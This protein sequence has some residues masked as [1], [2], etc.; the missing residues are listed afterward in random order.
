MS[1]IS[2]PGKNQC[3]PF[4]KR[5]PSHKTEKTLSLIRL[6]KN[7]FGKYLP[8]TLLTILVTLSGAGHAWA[9]GGDTCRQKEQAILEQLEIAQED[10]NPGRIQGLEKALKNIRAWCSDSGLLAK[11]NK[12]VEE[13][14]TKVKEREAELAE[15]IAQGKEADKISKRKQKLEEARSEL[16]KALSERDTLLKSINRAGE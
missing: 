9:S 15:S 5:P 14:Q 16:R 2:Q 8:V 12:N 10:D 11:A 1:I 13:E 6:D 4:T 3:F 7:S